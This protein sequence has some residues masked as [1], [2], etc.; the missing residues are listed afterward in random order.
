MNFTAQSKD[1]R[2]RLGMVSTFLEKRLN[3]RFGTFLYQAFKFLGLV[4]VWRL[5]VSGAVTVSGSILQRLLDVSPCFGTPSAFPSFFLSDIDIYPSSLDTFSAIKE[6]YCD[7]GY[8]A[9]Q[10]EYVRTTCRF[11]AIA[12]GH[13]Y[14]INVIA[15]KQDEPV[16]NSIARFDLAYLALSFSA[17]L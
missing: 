15:P 5:I 13:H 4:D 17:G 3:G 14:S 10:E 1:P 6:S 8:D 11:D 12:E 9:I 16:S 2:S 7:I